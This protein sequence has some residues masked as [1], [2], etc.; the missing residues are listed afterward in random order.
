MVILPLLVAFIIGWACLALAS[1]TTT[2]SFQTPADA[3]RKVQWIKVAID[4]DWPDTNLDD[5]TFTLPY[6]SGLATRIVS[7]S[8][9]T[10]T[11]WSLILKDSYGVTIFSKT[12]IN[13]ADE[14]EGWMIS[15]DDSGGDPW[16]GVPIWGQMTLDVDN[17]TRQ[18]EVQTAT[19]AND[20]DA[21]TYTITIDGQTTSA[22]AYNV[23]TAAI[24][25]N[26]EALSNI[27]SGK[28]TSVV[29]TLDAANSVP[30]V[31]TFNATIGNVPTMTI[32]TTDTNSGT[33]GIVETTEG[34]NLFDALNV[35]IF[36]EQ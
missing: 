10:D 2:A 14:P 13:S 5:V 15:E 12:D 1:H 6:Y 25:A 11:S 20:A 24:D 4:N 7:D 31:F 28:V 21:G 34:G 30:M 23:A 3:D 18:A 32:T 26:L 9:G 22:M 16:L 17:V 19:A 36:L 29:S 27:G 35:Y 33:I 8:N